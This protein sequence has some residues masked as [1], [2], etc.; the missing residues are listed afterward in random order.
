[1]KG[2][3]DTNPDVIKGICDTTGCDVIKG[4]YD[5]NPDVIKGIYDT[6]D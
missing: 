6:T 3:Y 2:T 4:T 5:T 1:M